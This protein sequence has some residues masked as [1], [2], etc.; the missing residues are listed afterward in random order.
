ME[1]QKPEQGLEEE[2]HKPSSVWDLFWHW[3]EQQKQTKDKE[4]LQETI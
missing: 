4:R 2:V 3:L 1:E